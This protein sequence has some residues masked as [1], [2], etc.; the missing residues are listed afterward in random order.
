MSKVHKF[1]IVTLCAVLCA[2]LAF[3]SFSP[4]LSVSSARLSDNSRASDEGVTVPQLLPWGNY[5]SSVNDFRAE[6][7]YEQL[8]FGKPY[9]FNSYLFDN[10]FPSEDRYDIDTDFVN[11]LNFFFTVGYGKDGQYY[12]DTFSTYDTFFTMK[13]FGRVS[14]FSFFNNGRELFL[15]IDSTDFSANNLIFMITLTSFEGFKYD[16]YNV[17]FLYM[18]YRCFF[19][20]NDYGA[21]WQ[22]WYLKA[23]GNGYTAG[24]EE[25]NGGYQK[26]YD[27]GYAV[28]SSE[29]YNNGYTAGLNTSNKYSFNSLIGSVIDAPITALTGLLNWDLFGVN[30]FSLFTALLTIAIALKVLS[31]VLGKI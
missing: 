11:C 14:D 17:A 13:K 18:L 7:F 30:V 23:Y 24:V 26:G 25:S 19:D 21:S 20:A 4:M 16:N 5:G 31:I 8:E 6:A 15:D 1:S 3:S 22:Y 29:G 9:M 10:Y 12:I 27:E 28:G 2:F